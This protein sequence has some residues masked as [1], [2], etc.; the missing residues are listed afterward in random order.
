MKTF[1][2]RT[3]PVENKTILVRVDYNVPVLKGKITNTAKIR[4]SLPTLTFLLQ[5]N[6]RIVLATHLGRPEGKIVPEL[7]TDCLVP[8]LQQLLPKIK[9]IKLNDCIGKEVQARIRSGKSND[10]FLLEDLRFYKEEEQNNPLFAHALASLADIYVNDAFANCHRAH[11]SVHAITQFCPS[12]PGF[13]V[14]KEISYLQKALQP[15]HPA[16]WLLGGAKL[17]KINL[18]QQALKTADYILIGGAL[19]FPFLRAQGIPTGMSAIDQASLHHAKEI[20]S[21]KASRKI[22]LPLDFVVADT[23]SSR[24]KTVIVPFN[25]IPAASFALDLGPETIELFKRYLRKAQ[26]VVWNGP[27]GYYEWAPFAG[28]TKDIGRFVGKLT[29]VSIAG[30]G[31][32]A[33]ALE[34]FHLTHAV[35]HLSTGGGAALAYL[36][37]KTLPGIDALEKNYKKFKHLRR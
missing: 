20:M 3:F 1:S 19:A 33:A 4:A 27:L 22:I 36:S 14:E 31:E 21:W 17:D 30:G 18:L 32:T 6:C 29:V 13:L 15:T 26:T 25:H 34:K 23:F 16:V 2:L 7:R 24:A 11:A 9:I 12:L 28:A 35:T 10:I 5:K 8:V 37:G